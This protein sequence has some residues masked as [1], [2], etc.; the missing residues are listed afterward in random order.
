MSPAVFD[1]LRIQYDALP[2]S[3]KHTYSYEEYRNMGDYG[4]AM[5][6]EQET[7]PDYTE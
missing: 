5:L 7:E 6:I 2:E 3:I 4:R 1:H